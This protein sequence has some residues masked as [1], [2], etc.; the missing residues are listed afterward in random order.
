MTETTTPNPESQVSAGDAPAAQPDS[1]NDFSWIG[2]DFQTDGRPDIGRFREHYEGLLA[3]DARLRDAPT[4]PADGKYDLSIPA[5]LDYGDLKPPEGTKIELLT[6]DPNFAPVFGELQAFL[7][8]NNLPQQT[9]SG[10]IGL[11]A[12]YQAAQSIAADKIRAAEIEKLGPTPGAR[13]SRLQSVQHGL[14]NRLPLDQAK[15]LLAATQS[16]EGV[17]ALEA[18]LA[19]NSGP[20]AANPSPQKQALNGLHGEALLRAARVTM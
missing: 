19:R 10:L 3:Q 1:G 4:A 11:L 6:D 9:A 18:L 14:A 20:M 2:Q 5:D 8:Q 7:Q 17:K 13:N 12:K 15:A 16:A